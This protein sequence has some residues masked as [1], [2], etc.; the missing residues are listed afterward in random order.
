MILTCSNRWTSLLIHDLNRPVIGSVLYVTIGWN[1]ELAM[2]NYE[3]AHF[4]E[5]GVPNFGHSAK[6]GTRSSVVSFVEY[7]TFDTQQFFLFFATNVFLTFTT[8]PQTTHSN[9]GHFDCL[10]VYFLVYFI[11]LIFFGKCKFELQGASK[12]DFI[13][14]KKYY[15]CFL[16]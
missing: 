8:L 16:V 14:S 5:C 6:I 4:T 15:P 9:L 12:I 2:M 13:R 10:L 7:P 11:L 3:K 1:Y